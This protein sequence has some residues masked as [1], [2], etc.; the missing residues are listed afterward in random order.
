MVM[1]SPKTRFNEKEYVEYSTRF[2]AAESLTLPERYELLSLLNTSYPDMVINN[3][4]EEYISYQQLYI[5][6]FYNKHKLV[7]S[8]QVLIVDDISRAPH[9][10]QEMAEVMKIKRFAIGSRAIVHPGYRGRG[11]GTELVRQLNHEVYSNNNIQ[12]VFGSSTS[13]SAI[14]L[15]IRLGAKLWN[16]E[17]RR[18]NSEETAHAEL[19]TINRLSLESNT[20]NFRMELPLYYVYQY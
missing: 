16:K 11:V 9:W 2:H 12:T 3:I 20:A 10:A 7:A 5:L 17:H 8:R 14:R 4:F 19:A 13:P 18:L 6:R 1:N 15:Y